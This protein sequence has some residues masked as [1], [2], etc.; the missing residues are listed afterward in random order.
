M[1]MVLSMTKLFISRDTTSVAKGSDW[2]ALELKGNYEIIRT[3]S[4]GLF[5]LEP[6]V[7]FEFEGVRHAFGPIKP[8]NLDAL[9]AAL[10]S[11][12]FSLS[13]QYMGAVEALPAL[14]MQNRLLFKRCGVIDPLNPECYQEFGG[15]V[16]LRRAIEC[17]PQRVI[18]EIKN[19][20]LRGRGGAAFPTGIKWQTVSDARGERKFIVCNADEGDSGTFADRMIMEGD[21]MSLLEGMVIAGIAVGATKGFIYLREEYPRAAEVLDEAITNFRQAG[22]LGKSVLGS[23]NEFDIELRIGAWAYICGEETSLLNSIEGKRGEVRAKP[24]LPAIEGL[25]GCPT[26][27]N[28]V[29]TLASVPTIMAEGSAYYAGFGAGNSKGTMPFQLAGNLANGSLVELAFGVTLHELLYQWGGGSKSGRPLR[30]VQVGGPLGTYLHPSEWSVE[31]TYEGLSS[32]GGVLGHGG[33]V[34]F[35]DTADMQR[36]AR[37]AMEFCAHESCGKC[38]PCRIGSQRGVELISQIGRGEVPLDEGRSLL[39]DL[40]DTMQFGSLCAMGGMTPFP[41]MS[42]LKH[43]SEDF[44]PAQEPVRWV[45]AEAEAQ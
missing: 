1:S 6:M 19:S 31:M 43:F 40:C 30:A 7:E 17:K 38:T 29:L 34:A 35:D 23:V 2:L 9:R 4:R 28:N 36:Q 42:A 13:S 22:I 39:I 41:V 3:G 37:F 32:I 8:E 18:D 16:G 45:E 11:Q 25:F 10:S 26:V 21:P 5:Y 24:P 15:L 27:V 44:G 12:N 14:T 20:G 33:I